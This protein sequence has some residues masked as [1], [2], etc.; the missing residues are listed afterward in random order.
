[1][2]VSSVI[3]RGYRGNCFGGGACT[4]TDTNQV[5]WVVVGSPTDP[6]ITKIP[7][8]SEICSGTAISAT[9]T[10]GTG[11][12]TC[13]NY[14]QYRIYSGSSWSAWY[15]YTTGNTINYP[16]NATNVEVRA[17]RGS[18]GSGCAASD[19]ALQS[20]IVNQSLVNPILAKTPNSVSVVSGTEVSASISIPGSQGVGCSDVLQFRTKTGAVYSAWSNYLENDLIPTTG[21]TEVQVRGFR[22]SCISGAAC[23]PADT[24][25]YSWLVISGPQNPTIVRNPNNDVCF[26]TPISATV[27]SNGG[28][29]SCSEYAQ[30]RTYVSGVW[31]AWTSYTSGNNIPY[32]ANT[33]QV[34]VRAWRG[35]C[36]PLSGD[37]VSD[38]IT[39]L[40]NITP[41]LTNPILIKNPT[42][43]TV[44]QGSNVSANVTVSGTGGVGCSD[45]LQYR[46]HNGTT[47]SAW[48]TYVEGNQINTSGYTQV[49]IRGIHGSCISGAEC[50]PVDTLIYSWTV[51]TGPVAPTIAKNPNQNSVCYGVPLSGTITPGSGG[52][53]CSDTYQSRTY[54]GTTWTAWTAYTSGSNVTYGVGT[55]QVQIRAFR[56]G[57][58]PSSGCLS[59]D[60]NVV[61]W[62][63]NTS[64]VNPILTKKSEH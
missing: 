31:S 48:A 35:N 20:W 61:S 63:L 32:P 4:P 62:T 34:E 21:L 5:T 23:P 60:T 52:S 24:L 22:G 56:G 59:S 2:G 27:T 36:D 10:N 41:V 3:V 29:V 44:C 37:V 16:S 54:N 6:T 25:I 39:S 18:C 1:M 17:F 26:G 28:G 46:V 19:T 57:C 50:P 47:F 33:T 43:A 45:L 9:I 64:L 55:Q 8:Q 51:I 49:Q 13:S 30:Y 15:N 58:N 40:W 11:G 12:I 7:N 42:D 53:G 14:A 38:T